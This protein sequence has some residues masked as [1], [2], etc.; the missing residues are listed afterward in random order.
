MLKKRE[1]ERKKRE[2]KEWIKGLRMRRKKRKEENKG[3]GEEEEGWPTPTM[4]FV[5]EME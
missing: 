1:L 3:R 5:V 2:K 4:K